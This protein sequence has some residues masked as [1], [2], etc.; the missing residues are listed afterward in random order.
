MAVGVTN[1]FGL[2]APAAGYVSESRRR[3]SIEVATVRNQLG[4]TKCVYPKPLVTVEVTN[5]GKGPGDL[6]LFDDHTLVSAVAT[7]QITSQKR[8]ENGN[9][10][11]DFET[12][13]KG[14][15]TISGS[16]GSAG[17]PGD[18]GESLGAESCPVF[19]IV[20]VNY[21]LTER[22]EVSQAYEEGEVVLATDGTF[23]RQDFYDPTYSFTVSG[24]GAFPAAAVLGTSGGLDATVAEFSAGVVLVLSSEEGE[25]NTGEPTWSIQGQCW[26]NAA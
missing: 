22:I 14:Y 11:P 15:L 17:T 19:G 16:A 12:T 2:S 23:A 3:K 7:Y 5:S 25:S 18:G 20:S 4:I 13:A 8:T 6:A 24:K 9:D 26:P 10:F 21:A 1:L